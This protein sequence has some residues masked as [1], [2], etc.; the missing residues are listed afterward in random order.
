MTSSLAIPLQ[1]LQGKYEILERL[2]EGGMGAIYKVRHRLLGE[3]RVVKL[4]R[5]HLESD[6]SLKARFLREAR[7]A[8]KLSHPNIAQIYDFSVDEDG[9]A[10]LV[11]EFIQGLTLGE[12][13]RTADASGE[14]LPLALVLEIARQSL[15]AIGHVHAHDIVHRDVSPD[16]LMLTRDAD[17]RPLVKLID[18]GLAKTIE[19]TSKLTAAGVFVGKFRYAAPEQF[20]DAF[21]GD[22]RRSDLYSFG[23][24]LYELLTGKCPIVGNN[25]SSL[26]AGHLFRPP[27]PF[28][29]SDPRGRVPPHVRRAVVKSLA[30]RAS[31]RFDSAESFAEAL[32][33]DD[34]DLA[35]PDVTSVVE[36]TQKI[37]RP[38]LPAPR[39]GSTQSRL[40]RNFVAEP[41]P[42]PEEPPPRPS[43]ATGEGAAAR[44]GPSPRP[45]P[46]TGEGAT[47][48]PGPRLGPSPRP[49]PATGEGATAHPGPRLGPS[50][51]SSPATAEG[52]S[53]TVTPAATGDA[54]T[55]LREARELHRRGRLEDAL[56]RARKAREIA[57]RHVMIEVLLLELEREVETRRRKE[58]DEASRR[59]TEAEIRGL[60][61]RGEIEAAAGRLPEALEVAGPTLVLRNL[62]AQIDRDL[63]AGTA[64]GKERRQSRTQRADEL[65]EA[66]RARARA[67][68]L[69]AAG[70]LLRQALN[71]VPGHAEALTLRASVESCLEVQAEEAREA[72]AV[73][74][75]LT[76]IRALLADG[77][78]A[79]AVAGVGQ[80]VRRFGHRDDLRVLHAEVARASFE[81]DADEDR[82]TEATVILENPPW[83]ADPPS[84]GPE[85]ETRGEDGA[86]DSGADAT[87]AVAEVTASIRQLQSRGE[88]GRALETL[89]LA[90]RAHGTL[91]VFKELRDEL[92]QAMLDQ[93][94]DEDQGRR[95]AVSEDG[96]AAPRPGLDDLP[97]GPEPSP[98]T[99]AFDETRAR[100]SSPPP[101]HKGGGG[102]WKLPL[103]LL[104]VVLAG[105]AV[106]LFLGQRG[107][108]G[109]A[110]SEAVP[111]EDVSAQALDPGFVVLD[112]VPWA[113]V[114]SIVPVAGA[115][116]QGGDEIDEEVPITP[117]R[118]TPVVLELLPGRYRMILSYP[119]GGQTQEVEVE[120]ASGA[121]VEQRVTFAPLDGKQYFDQV[122]W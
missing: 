7:A 49:S 18:L 102:G 33:E 26:I 57:P 38:I 43:P 116:P 55:L 83:A 9:V 22:R 81:A 120:V 85:A 94:A 91:E 118:Y 99:R 111:V 75:T 13:Q 10:Y 41:T 48:H 5:P 89:Q 98:R 78:V 79:E 20:E 80:A 67:E 56:A 87:G 62:R 32:A 30:K 112:A 106:G 107:Q 51:R 77:Q 54:G 21:E 72:E 104:L 12:L 42:A 113:E 59:S 40:D 122:G 24:V 119:P 60:V 11:M 70:E 14:L 95:D 2:Q 109:D 36:S 19:G 88:H 63:E 58:V 44:P 117:S 47:A 93:D 65:V 34:W 39:P 86:A 31:E 97:L 28:A 1:R 121:E 100:P 46:A 115:P 114:L 105:L 4:I 52:A 25:P 101:T 17:G 6:P 45:S 8:A 23:V 64:A 29:E 53:E 92:G 82:S 103:V 50:P 110:E 15:R 16:N 66:A 84:S 3:V 68:E 108:P 96:G 73:E 71:L 69:A 37:V 61:D 35:A 76:S 74:R 27:L 90:V